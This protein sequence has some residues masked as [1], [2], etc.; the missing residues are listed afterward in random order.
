LTSR[1]VVEEVSMSRSSTQARTDRQS[2]VRRQ[3]VVKIR[4]PLRIVVTTER[5]ARAVARELVGLVGLDVHPAEGRWEVTLDCIKTDRLLIRVIDAV[6]TSLASDP[7][8]S[9]LVALEGREYHIRP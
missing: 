5:Q 8:G 6:R 2:P 9:A 1:F 3:P 7:S 4:E